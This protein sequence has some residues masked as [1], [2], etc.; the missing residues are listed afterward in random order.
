MMV[1][2]DVHDNAPV[3]YGNLIYMYTPA[4]IEFPMTTYHWLTKYAYK[5]FLFDIF[6]VLFNKLL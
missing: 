2:L 3:V 5:L 4:D 1:V 6:C